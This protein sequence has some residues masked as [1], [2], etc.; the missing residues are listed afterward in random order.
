MKYVT[1]IGVAALFVLVVTATSRAQDGVITGRVTDPS[2]AVLPG[3]DATL[4][5]TAVM[6]TRSVVTDEQGGYRFGQLPPGTYTVKFQLP[7]F[8]TVVRE[9]IQLTAGFTSTLNL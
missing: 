9:G 7:G 8:G 4:T 2:G 1:R 5:S 3:V 6:G